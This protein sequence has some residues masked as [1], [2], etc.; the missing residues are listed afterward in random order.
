MPIATHAV[1]IETKDT[2]LTLTA[3]D[4]PVFE[5]GVAL[6]EVAEADAE[7]SPELEGLEANVS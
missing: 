2:S 4:F 1:K 7:E 6:G 5:A 3:A